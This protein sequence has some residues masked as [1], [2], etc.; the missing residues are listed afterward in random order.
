MLE[1]WIFYNTAIWIITSY[2]SY[3]LLQTLFNF[4]EIYVLLTVIN[5]VKT[6]WRNCLQLWSF[7]EY[8]LISS[9]QVM[10]SRYKK[11]S[12]T[13]TLYCDALCLLWS[14]PPLALYWFIP[15]AVSL[16]PRPDGRRNKVYIP[17]DS[18]WCACHC[19]PGKWRNELTPPAILPLPPPPSSSE[20]ENSG[21]KRLT[22]PRFLLIPD[23]FRRKAWSGQRVPL[24]MSTRGWKKNGPCLIFCI[25]WIPTHIHTKD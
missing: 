8:Y 5:V 4:L 2:S 22:R 14:P 25:M 15:G 6:N 11:R 24:I 18:G 21:V 17:G 3:E 19:A 20:R 12:K 1:L 9:W 13:V 23:S 10:F 16:C 7:K